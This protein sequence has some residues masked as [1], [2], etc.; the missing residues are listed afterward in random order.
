MKKTIRHLVIFLNAGLLTFSVLSA[1][2]SA[3]LGAST[4][5]PG[6]KSKSLTLFLE[7]QAGHSDGLLIL[8]TFIFALIAIPILVH[9]WN[10]RS[11]A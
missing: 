3:A 1:H 9:Y 8:G 5:T 4:P 2:F 6:P 7:T 10:F 11:Q